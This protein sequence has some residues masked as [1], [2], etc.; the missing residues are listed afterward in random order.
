MCIPCSFTPVYHV[1]L[2]TSPSPTVRDGR[3]RHVLQVQRQCSAASV[4]EAFTRM[5]WRRNVS[6]PGAIFFVLISSI[7]SRFLAGSKARSFRY[8]SSQNQSRCFDFGKE[9]GENKAQF[10]SSLTETER[11]ELLLTSGRGAI[12]LFSRRKGRMGGA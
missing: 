4:S 7:S 6:V 2:D 8:S 3:T 5:A 9:E 1:S 12:F 11:R 10:S